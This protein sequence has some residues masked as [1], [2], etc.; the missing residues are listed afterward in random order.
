MQSLILFFFIESWY[1]VTPEIVA[2]H[3]AEKCACD[4]IVDAFCG[5]GGNSIQFALTCNR[6]TRKFFKQFYNLNAVVTF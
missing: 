3:A 4:V 2:K 5:A 1:S 6:G